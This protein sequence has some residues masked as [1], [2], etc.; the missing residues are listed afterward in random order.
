MN[1]VWNVY[2]CIY[3]FHNISLVM[4]QSNV[5]LLDMATDHNCLRQ[6]YTNM[7]S[8]EKQKITFTEQNHERIKKQKKKQPN[9][10]SSR[11]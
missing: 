5:P 8:K 2:L 9:K 4:L 6:Q 7:E 11:K 10:Q 3:T 1:Q